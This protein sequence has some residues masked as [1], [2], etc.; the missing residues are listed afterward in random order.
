[1]KNQLFNIILSNI[2]YD[3]IPVFMISEKLKVFTVTV[4][5][6]F[7]SDIICNIMNSVA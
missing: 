4:S 5:Y 1:M 2:I 7:A 3:I 6:D